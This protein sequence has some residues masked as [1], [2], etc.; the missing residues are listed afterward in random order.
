MSNEKKTKWQLLAE[1]MPFKWKIQSFNKDK[2]KATCV[3]YV[4][5]RDVMDK[6]DK[7]L[8]PDNW[9][10]IH[11]PV[12]N[13]IICGI[14][15]RDEKGSWIFKED[16]G[17]ENEIEM[18]KSIISDSFKRCAVNWGV[19]R[20]LYDLDIKYVNI[21][22]GKPIDENGNVI[23]NLTEY[24]N[25]K[26]KKQITRTSEKTEIIEKPWLNIGTEEFDK[27]IGYIIAGE[28]IEKI[29]KK[30]KLSKKVRA[31]LLEKQPA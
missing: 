31:L 9:Q 22:N 11:K 18:E 28:P 19:G 27:A 12:G 5:A 29:E 15:I 13:L 3:A 21:S 14:G 8:G 10:R 16:V 30:F 7:V 17:S 23:W 20:F 24:F 6:F 4:D 25:G 26:E 1:P 2:T